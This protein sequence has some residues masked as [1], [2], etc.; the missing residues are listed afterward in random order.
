MAMSIDFICSNPE[1]RKELEVGDELAGKK[2]RCPK[3]KTVVVVPR[4]E[5]VGGRETGRG[6]EEDPPAEGGVEAL[7]AHL[8]RKRGE[9]APFETQEEIAHG[10][11]GAVILA[12]DKAIQRELAV[13]VMRPQIADS[14]EHRLRF[15]EEAQVTGQLEHPNIVPIHELGKD[16]EGNLYFTMKLVKGR[17]L[18]QIIE[19]M[20]GEGASRQDAKTPGEDGGM[21]GKGPRSKRRPQ[22]G[23][24]L[25]SRESPAEAERTSGLETDQAERG[26]GEPSVRASATVSLPD[27]LNIF[28]KVCD[29]IAFAHSRGVVHRDLKPDNI[30]VGEFGE[31][32][33]MDWGL[34]KVAS[35]GRAG[36]QPA[37]SEAETEP[38]GSRRAQDAH[39]ADTK[40]A[41]ERSSSNAPLRRTDS[42]TSDTVRSVRIDSD[43]ALTMEGAVSGT[44]AYMP[45]EQAEGKIDQ[46]DHRSD[47]YSLGAILYEILTLERPIEGKTQ[48]E[49]LLKVAE[50]RII[51][52]E[53][54]APGRQI[55]KEL[56]AVTLKAM[57]KRRRKR[58]QSVPE[59]AQDIRLFLEGR[60]VSAKEDSFVESV[61]KLVKRNKPVT[62]AVGAA[63][64]VVIVLTVLFIGRVRSERDRA[65]DS[66]RKALVDRK[67]AQDAREEQR[68]TALAASRKFAMQAIR[69]AEG[70]RWDEARRRAE[71]VVTVAPDSPW[72]PYTEGVFASL[73]DDLEAA[74]SHFR[75]ALELDPRHKQSRAALSDLLARQGDVEQARKFLVDIDAQTDWR[76]LLRA[77]R[78]LY[79][80]R[81][82][83]ESQF[84]GKRALELMERKNDTSTRVELT[85]RQEMV[86][87]IKDCQDQIEA[88]DA[89]AACEGFLDE[90]K[91]LHPTERVRRV[92]KKLEE[93]ND[94]KVTLEVTVENGEWVNVSVGSEDMRF[95]AP[96]K[97]LTI[98]RLHVRG[99]AVR[100]LTP[101]SGMPLAR[102]SMEYTPVD[103]LSPLRGM[104]LR[105][106][107]CKGLG[108]LRDITPLSGMPLEFAEFEHCGLLEDIAPLNGAPLRELG[109]QWTGVSD[110]NALQGTPLEHLRAPNGVTDISALKGAPLKRLSLGSDVSDLGP[111]AGSPLETLSMGAAKIT[112]LSPLQGLPLKSLTIGHCAATDMTPLRGLP[113]QTLN[114]G[115]SALSDLSFVGDM[116]LQSLSISMLDE[117]HKLI[118]ELRPTL[119]D[120]L[121]LIAATRWLTD[122]NLRAAG[123]HVNF[124]TVGRER[125]LPRQLETT[126]FRAIQEAVYNI[127]RHA[128]ARNVIISLHFRKR[129]IR[130]HIRDDGRGFDV[131]E[132]IDSKDRPRGL[133]LLG[134]KERVELISGSLN[135]RSQSGGGTEIVIEIPLAGEGAN[136]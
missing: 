7:D 117:I 13:K 53:Q 29:G 24:A 134:M 129:A 1:C 116:P 70:G 23:S 71:D 39:E 74:A 82:W 80:A 99:R 66:E 46:I 65:L 10:G 126:F 124:K 15:L 109:L 58:Y 38:A 84:A 130:V 49:V 17:S 115:S 28:L 79:A 48:Y 128:H 88:E 103:D 51:R 61:V 36:S 32:Q 127:A 33:I 59:L 31:V 95:I 67:A 62:A 35:P 47:I 101:L 100:V 112:D 9:E 89:M 91:G 45:P 85:T 87:L 136:G 107:G 86:V 6:G 44:P 42:H 63:A 104:P 34:A 72:G 106:L 122:K 8:S 97:G 43:V 90:L 55:P 121:G 4:A 93:V 37:S 123:V 108:R 111:L 113:L 41:D 54:R 94:A 73:Q 52:P 14:E 75:K 114:C 119:L 3:C 22:R 16:A 56:S 64:L 60:A 96:L 25:Q 78:T 76:T 118:Y 30:M 21:K 19:E 133:G 105:F 83:K 98:R 132:A 11:M 18:G 27:L 68:K 92:K 57:E 26:I 81:Q 120:D 77:G 102:F 2:A 135:I 12:R 5:S 50:G 20:R 69:A 131:Q 110:I 125:R 40:P